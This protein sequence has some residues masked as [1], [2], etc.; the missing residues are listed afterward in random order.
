LR[1]RN[2]RGVAQPDIWRVDVLANW[3]SRIQFLGK[4]GLN[5]LGLVVGTNALQRHNPHAWRGFGSHGG[6]E[7]L[8]SNTDAVEFYGRRMFKYGPPGRTVC[9]FVGVDNGDLIIGHVRAIGGTV[10]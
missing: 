5:D 9:D 8:A 2:P 3:R 7:V 1:G 10:V 4:C 6:T